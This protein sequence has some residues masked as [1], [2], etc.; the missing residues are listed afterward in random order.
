MQSRI[1]I[2]RILKLYKLCFKYE[3]EQSTFTQTRG[4]REYKVTHTPQSTLHFF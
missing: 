1:R 2:R 3:N 4:G